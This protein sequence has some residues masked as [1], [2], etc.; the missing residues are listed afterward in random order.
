MLPRTTSCQW[1]LLR[2]MI[3]GGRLL[4]VGPRLPWQLLSDVNPPSTGALMDPWACVASMSCFESFG[5][6]AYGFCPAG[7]GAVYAPHGILA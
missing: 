5:A 4:L 3:F 6:V 2:D 1:D 7:A